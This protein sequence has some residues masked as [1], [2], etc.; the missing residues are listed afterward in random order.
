[1]SKHQPIKEVLGTKF[2]HERSARVMNRL[3]HA[4]KS[5]TQ[6][7]Q[8]SAYLGSILNDEGISAADPTAAMPPI[9][10]SDSV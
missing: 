3:S 9:I 8:L 6:G 2:G 5:G 4:Y 1:M 10:Y 7:E